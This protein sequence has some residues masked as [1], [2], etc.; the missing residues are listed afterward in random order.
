[1]GF[2]NP[3][4]IRAPGVASGNWGCG[5]FGGESLLKALLQLMVC[6]VVNRPL[7]YFTFENDELRDD[8]FAMYKFLI[9]KEV[10]VGMVYC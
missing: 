1:M 5:A 10:T 4:S 2:Y 3:T 8:V 9:E 7:V 6:T